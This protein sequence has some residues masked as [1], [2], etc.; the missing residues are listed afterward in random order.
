MAIS[1]CRDTV[2]WVTEVFGTPDVARRLREL[3]SA[4]ATA[5]EFV[6][7]IASLSHPAIAGT[8]REEFGQLPAATVMTVIEAWAMAD[9]GNKPFEMVSVRPEEPVA[10][11]RSRRV[12][13]TVD[14]EEDA[15]RVFLS[16]IPT[17]HADWYSPL[18]LSA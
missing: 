8:I 16:H 17:R 9:A 12:R 14:A 3:R 11:A 2:S 15:V 10:F 13:V 6:E 7:A 5:P 1:S 18:A 4:H